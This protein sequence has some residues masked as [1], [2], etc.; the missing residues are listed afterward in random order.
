V[1]SEILEDIRQGEHV[2]MDDED[3]E[4]GD[5]IGCSPFRP[6]D[7]N[8]GWKAPADLTAAR[9]AGGFACR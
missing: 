3:R 9:A 6:K 5:L 1:Q 7:V 2:I 8:P 4:N